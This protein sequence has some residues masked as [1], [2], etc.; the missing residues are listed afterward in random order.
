MI[1]SIDIEDDRWRAIEDLE[2]LA[3]LALR[4][5]ADQFRST[6]EI[7]ILF[8]TDAQIAD[9][10]AH[11]RKKSGPTNVLSFPA[12][13]GVSLPAGVTRPLGDIVL[14]YETVAREAGEQGKSLRN[15][16]AHLVVH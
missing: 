9:L 1:F 15:H 12:P 7:V 13:A 14:A 16:T 4:H 5:C 10:N 3:R 8:S 6:G 11:W 2:A